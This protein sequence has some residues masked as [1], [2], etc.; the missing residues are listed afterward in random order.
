MDW[1]SDVCSSDLNINKP[2]KD[3]PGAVI[4]NGP[5]AVIDRFLQR[6]D[7][8]ELGYGDSEWQSSIRKLKQRVLNIV[9]QCRSMMED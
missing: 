8:P 9:E 7:T 1:S 5:G 6:A 4:D 3:G 2:G